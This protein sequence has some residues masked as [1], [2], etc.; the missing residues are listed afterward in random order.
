MQALG[1]EVGDQTEARRFVEGK[2]RFREASYFSRNPELVAA[3]KAELGLV[4]MVCDFDF[5]AAYGDVGHGYI[6]CH[7]LYEMARDEERE[8]TVSDVAVVCAN[9]HK[10]IH[11]GGKLRS[12]D[13]MKNL[14]RRRALPRPRPL[15]L[16]L[17]S[18]PE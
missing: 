15:P 18:A 3:A 14:L 7:H 5:E 8:T 9:C 1:F 11:R 12:I 6:E 2:R 13:E 10:M 4:C 16:P 17:P